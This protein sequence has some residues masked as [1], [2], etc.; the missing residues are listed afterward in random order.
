MAS[1]QHNNGLAISNGGGKEEA[2]ASNFT[3]NAS[4]DNVWLIHRGG[5]CAAVRCPPL[6]PS[7]RGTENDHKTS[8]C[9]LHNG[10][11][12]TVD[13]DD[14]E[15]M[16]PSYLDLVEDICELKHLNEASVLH[17]L[18]QRFASNLI[19]TKAGSILLVVNPMAPLSLYSDKVRQF[20]CLEYDPYLCSIN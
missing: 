18:R 15:Q 9:L 11:K 4:E 5:F 3:S 2:D 1:A 12:I 17:C 14:V 16:N 13:E 20:D 19:H 8:I 10:E 7:N 6:K